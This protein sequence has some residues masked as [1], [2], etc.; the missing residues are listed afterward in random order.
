MNMTKEPFA[1]EQNRRDFLKGTS[2][3]TMMTLMGAIPIRAAE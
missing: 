3:A 2:F 1:N